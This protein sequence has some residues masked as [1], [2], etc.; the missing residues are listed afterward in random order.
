MMFQVLLH[1]IIRYVARAP[2]PVT[3]RPQMTTPIALG[4]LGKFLLQYPRGAPLIRFISSLIAV[5][6]DILGEYAHGPC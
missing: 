6:E 3:H 5:R 4:P 1:P 2:S